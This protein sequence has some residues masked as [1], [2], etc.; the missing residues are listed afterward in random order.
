MRTTPVK[1]S[2]GIRQ[3]AEEKALLDGVLASSPLS[4][5]EAQK[6]V[7]ELQVYRIELEMQNDELRLKQDALEALH[8]PLTLASVVENSDNIV[9]CKDADKTYLL[10]DGQRIAHIGSWELDIEMNTLNWSDEIYRIFGVEPLGTLTN[11]DTFLDCVH[12][13]DR[14][15]V[16]GIFKQSFREGTKYDIVH[17]IIRKSDHEIRY[18]HE[19]CRHIINLE[20]RVVRSAGTVQDVTELVSKKNDLKEYAHHIVKMIE[21]ERTRIARELHDELGQSLTVLSFAITQ[22]KHDHRARKTVLQ[23][24]LDMQSGVDQMMESIRRICTALRPTLMDELGLPAALEWL[25][26]DFTRRTGLPCT[27]TV[28]NNCCSHSN[29]ECC[30]AI[31][32]I[33]QESL[34]N[35]M[36]HAGA[37]RADILLS[38]NDGTVY[39][40]I[41]D[42]GRGIETTK[43]SAERSFGII[44]MRERAHS[45]GA[46]FKIT[47]KK[48]KGT[49]VKLAIPCKGQEGTDALSH[50]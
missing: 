44:G 47:G 3:R 28:K 36:K 12:P 21:N 22:I 42:D 48:G 9:V 25:C 37:S 30:L 35:T 39:L 20:G 8:I 31:F 38:R 23:S 40:E 11:Y 4:L 49:S 43:R 34:N 50:C 15:S 6:L 24:L 10:T 7:H 5:A 26:K 1:T 14:S 19:Q 45:L 18:V 32:R 2:P 46:T 13:E 27:S 29:M 17:R 16:D 41:N 33:V